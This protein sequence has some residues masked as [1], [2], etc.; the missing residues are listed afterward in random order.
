MPENLYK[1]FV[2]V[3]DNIS[4]AEFY[5][6]LDAELF[7]LYSEL[8]DSAEKPLEELVHEFYMR[9]NMILAES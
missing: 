1:E 8:F 7:S 4:G 2:K 5:T 3:R 6:P 9:M